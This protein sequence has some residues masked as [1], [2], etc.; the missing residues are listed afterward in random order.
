[1]ILKSLAAPDS[2][3]KFLSLQ[4]VLLNRFDLIPDL[5]ATLAQNRSLDTLRIDVGDFTP[6]NF[7]ILG[8]AIAKNGTLKTL[9]FL[10]SGAPKLGRL[11]MP[12][13][14]RI[15]RLRITIPLHQDMLVGMGKAK[16][17]PTTEGG[18]YLKARQAKK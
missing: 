8:E 14:Q 18:A 9:H 11:I 17:D 15:D 13:V 6:E 3:L 5:A 2:P 10:H 1:Q 16:N 7:K 12:M 4:F